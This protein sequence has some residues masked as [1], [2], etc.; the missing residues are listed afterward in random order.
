[1]SWYLLDSVKLTASTATVTLGA[2]G[3]IPQTYKSLRLLLSMRTDRVQNVDDIGMSYNQQTGSTSRY[4]IF[5]PAASV[6]SG[7]YSQTY[8]QFATASTAAANTFGMVEVTIP[9]YASTT[10]TKGVISSGVQEDNGTNVRMMLLAGLYP[11]NTPITS[12]TFWSSNAANFVSGSSF[13][14]Y[15]LK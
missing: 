7:T 1:M 6:S 14:L 9:N 4:L 10:A 13:Y 2:G 3:T 8:A 11:K 15:G 12:L 5:N